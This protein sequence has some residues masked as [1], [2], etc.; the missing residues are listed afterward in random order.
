[1]ETTIK[2]EN[3]NLLYHLSLIATFL[4]SCAGI[5]YFFYS[6]APSGTIEV[7]RVFMPTLTIVGLGVITGNYSYTSTA[8]IPSILFMIYIGLR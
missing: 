6:G 1:M 4:F 8:C 3:N 5:A 2:N 7:A